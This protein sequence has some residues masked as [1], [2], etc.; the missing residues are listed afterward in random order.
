MEATICVHRVLPVL[1]DSPVLFSSAPFDQ[2]D[3]RIHGWIELRI[4]ETEPDEN[5]AA[6]TV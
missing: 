3:S 6:N 1:G 4:Q 2:D 5:Y